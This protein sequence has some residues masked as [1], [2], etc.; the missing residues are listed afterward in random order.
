MESCGP[1]G[2]VV[3]ATVAVGTGVAATVGTEVGTDR[4][5]VRSST[6]GPPPPHPT[7]PSTNIPDANTNRNEF[8]CT[9]PFSDRPVNILTSQSTTPAPHPYSSLCVLCDL[10]GESST[11]SPVVG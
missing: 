10:C 9:P 3:A 2:T 8:H 11:P 7:T 4:V 5:S 6:C 1:A